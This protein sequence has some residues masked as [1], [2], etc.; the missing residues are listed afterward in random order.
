MIPRRGLG[1]R[2]LFL[3]HLLQD[4]L[5]DAELLQQP[6]VDVAAVGA[7]VG[8]HLLLVDAP[9]LADR[10]LLALDRCDDV[11]RAGGAGAG[12]SRRKLGM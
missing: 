12:P 6:L 10:D 2:R 8:L 4:P 5:V 3:D 7:A 11:A 1:Q 9:E